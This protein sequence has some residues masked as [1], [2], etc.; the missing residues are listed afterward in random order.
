MKNFF[1]YWLVRKL[2]RYEAF[3]AAHLAALKHARSNYGGG[4]PYW[5]AGFVYVGDPDVGIPR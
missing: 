4:H 1:D 5:W 3:H 2:P